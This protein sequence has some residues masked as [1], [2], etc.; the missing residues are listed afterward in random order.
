[1]TRKRKRGFVDGGMLKR[2]C[3][4]RLLP[5][6]GMLLGWLRM[7][8]LCGL[9][10][11][12]CGGK[13]RL[14]DLVGSRFRIRISMRGSV[15]SRNCVLLGFDRSGER[16]LGVE[17]GMSV[18]LQ[19]WKVDVVKE[20]LELDSVLYL[21][22][23]IP[24]L[25]DKFQIGIAESREPG[26]IA[27]AWGEKGK[28]VNLSISGFPNL[29][30]TVLTSGVVLDSFRMDFQHLTLAFRASDT[31]IGLIKLG[32]FERILTEEAKD[33]RWLK[34]GG[35]KD[36]LM[37]DIEEIVIELVFNPSG[38]NN[39]RRKILLDF[40]FGKFRLNN[41]EKGLLIVL[42]V[43]TGSQ[44]IGM[45]VEINMITRTLKVCESFAR[46]ITSQS[47]KVVLRSLTAFL[48]EFSEEV[49]G[50]H[51]FKPQQLISS[52]TEIQSHALP[53]TIVP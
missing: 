19:V 41:D 44:D 31:A 53:V 21:Q 11:W 9:G 27:V 10:S 16:V 15:S 24:L 26:F 18:V 32:C 13:M 45:L 8:E 42:V 47:L 38:K 51:T 37:I 28:Q 2:A 39:K 40:E 23:P 17:F 35:S 4:V 6:E 3:K 25:T 33:C 43:R 20:R 50:V 34:E 46:E 30:P 22:A 29:V 7:R 1:M 14:V 5:R 48:P 36:C 49:R 52:L 12:C